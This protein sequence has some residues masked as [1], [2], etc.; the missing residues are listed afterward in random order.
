VIRANDDVD[1]AEAV[2]CS[3]DECFHFGAFRY[4]DGDPDSRIA[5]GRN[6][7]NDGIDPVLAPRS[8][9]NSGSVSGK[10]LCSAFSNAATRSS[11]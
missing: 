11:D 1:A 8:H 3:F 9:Y 6:V 4:I 5:S 10:K 2:D 7:F